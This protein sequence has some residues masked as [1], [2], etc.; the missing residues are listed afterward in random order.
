VSKPRFKT[1]IEVSARYNRFGS[2][3]FSTD[4]FI[5]WRNYRRFITL[6][7]EARKAA[8]KVA[9]DTAQVMKKKAPIGSDRRYIGKPDTRPRG[10]L[11][12]AIVAQKAPDGGY[13]EWNRLNSAPHWE[14]VEFG[15]RPHI[16]TGPKGISFRAKGTIKVKGIKAPQPY[17][18]RAN[19][20][21]GTPRKGNINVPYVKHPG[22][23]P[24][25]YV[26]S[27]IAWGEE[28]LWRRVV[29]L[30]STMK[31]PD[32][33]HFLGDTVHQKARKSTSRGGKK[34]L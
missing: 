5:Y 13:V 6:P 20:G 24:Q 14:A 17:F 1:Y 32:T 26:R 28:E 34:P 2:N 3:N 7:E 12:G 27:S 25:P 19:P 21:T 33:G 22:N 18:G 29:G 11:R 16:I 23:S 4:S 30:G 15:A 8:Y 9:Q 31:H 10:R